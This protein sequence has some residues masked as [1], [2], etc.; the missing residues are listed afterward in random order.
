MKPGPGNYNPNYNYYK[1]KQ[2]NYGYMGIKSDDN[3][4][5]E[6]EDKDERKYYNIDCQIGSNINNY[7]F[8]NSP[9][10]V[11][12]TSKRD[13]NKKNESKIHES[14]LKYSSFGEQIMTQKDTRPIYSFG[15]QDRFNTIK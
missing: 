3:S 15:K 11:F 12:G 10:F 6:D 14:Y 9:K 4:Q 5:N 8:S 7:K 2:Y 13:L 1:Y